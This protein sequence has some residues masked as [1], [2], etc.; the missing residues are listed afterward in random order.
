[1]PRGFISIWL[2]SVSRKTEALL[3]KSIFD[4]KVYCWEYSCIAVYTVS[5]D[6]NEPI[7]TAMRDIMSDFF[8]LCRRKHSKRSNDL[9]RW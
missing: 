2:P 4:D 5:A 3:T 9:C 8:P 6:K 7:F 1:M